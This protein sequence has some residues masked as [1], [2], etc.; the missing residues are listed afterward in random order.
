MKLLICGT[1]S[2]RAGGTI[3]PA[4]WPHHD[5]LIVTG[6]SVDLRCGTRE[7]VLRAHDAVLIP[8][9][10]DFVGKAGDAGGAIWVQHCVLAPA[11][12]APAF[13]RSPGLVVRQ[14]VAGSEMVRAVLRRLHELRERESAADR[15]LRHA[16]FRTLLLELAQ[17][18]PVTGAVRA[19]VSRLQPAIEW[20]ETNP[21][22]TPGLRTLAGRARL[23]ESHFR[24][25]FR[26]LRGQPA[27]AWLRERRMEEAWRL[28]RTTE[29]TLKEIAA[30]L[31]YGD[32]VSFNRAFARHHG[33]PPGRFRRTSPKLV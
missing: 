14:G 22:A 28:L 31:G 25:L 3:G 20:A 8:P 29:L 13:G 17:P 12:L 21:G 11:D 16:L 23:S 7:L 24:S 33:T 30:R 32:V 5:L 6:G 19:G 26:K 2:Y 27:G 1:G 10:T 9:G 15:R 4:R 18:A